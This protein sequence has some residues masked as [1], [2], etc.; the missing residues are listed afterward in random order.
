[1]G[2]ALVKQKHFLLGFGFLACLV[3]LY[4]A[5]AEADKMRD[6]MQQLQSDVAKEQKE[7]HTLEAELTYLN[8]YERIEKTAKENLGLVSQDA[9]QFIDMNE[10]DQYAPIHQEQAPP[11][12][13]PVENKETTPKPQIE[14]GVK[15]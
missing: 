9:S 6:H 12:V 5:K 10:I 8:T 1:M 15:K 11:A 13:T 7:I 3:P 2:H 4:W 14:N